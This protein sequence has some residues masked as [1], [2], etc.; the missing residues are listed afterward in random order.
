MKKPVCFVACYDCPN[1]ASSRTWQF[2]K[3]LSNNGHAITFITSNYNHFM[4]EKR[5]INGLFYEEE[6]LNGI[7]VVWINSLNFGKNFFLRFLHLVFYS[8]LSFIVS[9]KYINSGTVTMG[10]SVPLPLSISALLAAKIK[11]SK[12]IF[13]IRDVWPEELIEIGSISRHGLVAKLLRFIEKLLCKKSQHIISALPNVGPHLLEIDKNL[14]FDYVPNPIDENLQYH[15]YNGGKDNHLRILYL[16][17]SGKAMSI[18]TILDAYFLL[19][20]ELN[21]EIKFIGPYEIVD[22]YLSKENVNKRPN[23]EYSNLVSRDKVPDYI[24]NADLLVHSIKNTDQLKFGINS[25]KLIEYCSSGRVVLLA[26]KVKNDLVS[27]SGC[28]Y[29]INPEDPR[30]MAEF[31]LKVRDMSPSERIKIGRKGQEFIIRQS[32]KFLSNKYSDI[33]ERI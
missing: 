7:K 27:S 11:R 32:S 33:I 3:G 30:L 17:G 23:L 2:S 18:E 26:A 25:N 22:H 6:V 14:S 10:T 24:N 31:F 28:G 8:V 29:V 13:E 1:G 5:K 21:I 16:G 19:P 15:D 12:F 20:E 4:I 9:L